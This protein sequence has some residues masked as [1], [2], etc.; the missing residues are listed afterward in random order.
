[1]VDILL[2]DKKITLSAHDKSYDVDFFDLV[3]LFKI[4]SKNDYVFV[5]DKKVNE[6]YNLSKKLNPKKTLII[7]SSEKIKDLKF[8][9]FMIESFKNIGVTRNMSVVCIGG[10]TLQDITQFVCS[11]YYRGIDIILVPTTLQAITD[12]CIGSKT[13]INYKN[14]KNQ[15]GTFYSP[16]AIFI[17]MEFLNTLSKNDI[18]SGVA[19]MLKLLIIGQS[20]KLK[21]FFENL[22]HFKNILNIP[23]LDRYIFEAL[24]IKKRFVELDIFDFNERKIL[25]YGHTFAHAIESINSNK[26]SHGNATAIGINLANYYSYRNNLTTKVFFETHFKNF[27]LIFNFAQLTKNLQ[28]NGVE[29]LEKFLNDKKIISNRKIQLIIPVNNSISIKTVNIDTKLSKIIDD[30]FKLIQKENN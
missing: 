24:V 22:H 30:F 17:S 3:K 20:Q 2:C 14:Y 21:E 6:L 10:G 18:N 25:N 19:E 26:I 29:F 23:D 1:M 7:K 8:A 15:L 5:V 28:L 27:D 9:N 13:S 11:I 12:S 4:I 16:K